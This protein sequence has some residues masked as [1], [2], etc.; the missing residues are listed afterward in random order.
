MYSIGFPP[1]KLFFV[2]ILRSLDEE[3]RAKGKIKGLKSS[4]MII[5]YPDE[6]TF[7]GVPLF[8]E[9][10][11]KIEKKEDKE[12]K[13]QSFEDKMDK[14]FQDVIQMINK[15]SDEMKDFK[16]QMNN[17]INYLKKTIDK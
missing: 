3:K 15:L 11:E 9:K 14:R 8:E 13:Q 10:K 1:E 4:N 16:I 7:L 17:D 5:I 12:E 6:L 2:G